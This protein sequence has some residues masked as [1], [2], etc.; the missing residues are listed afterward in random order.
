M[1]LSHIKS[2]ENVLPEKEYKMLVD[3]MINKVGPKNFPIY[4]FL[5]KNKTPK[6]LLEKVITKLIGQ[7]KHIEYWVRYNDACLWHVDA[8]EVYEKTQTNPIM[9]P[10]EH[11]PT[12]SYCYYVYLKDLKG[13]DFQILP[14]NYHEEGRPTMD[15]NYEPREGDKVIT[16]TPRNNYIVSWEGPLYHRVKK[17]LGGERLCL[18]WSTWDEVPRGYKNGL[19]WY[20]YDSLF[21]T[22]AYRRG[23]LLK[24]VKWPVKEER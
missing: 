9:L 24:E 18:V 3:Y 17:I 15:D 19:H 21:H 4:N 12:H 14:K 10:T 5:P 7:E 6:N 23:Y 13:G 20:W 11:F 22:A 16:L 1:D 2:S 8:D